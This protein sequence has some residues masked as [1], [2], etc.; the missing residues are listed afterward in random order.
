MR[1]STRL[2]KASLG[3]VD[4][5]NDEN[6]ASVANQKET[7]PRSST[8]S[9]RK[10]SRNSSLSLVVKPMVEDIE[11]K[12][13]SVEAEF[14]KKMALTMAEID[15]G[16][17][18]TSTTTK[19]ESELTP[20]RSEAGT[21]NVWN[22]V[23][24][25]ATVT[26]NRRSSV[27]KEVATPTPAPAAAGVEETKNSGSD[28]KDEEEPEVPEDADPIA[29]E[30]DNLELDEEAVIA[31]AAAEEEAAEL[32]IRNR[33]SALTDPDFD[34][35]LQEE[36]EKEE[37]YDDIDELAMGEEKEVEQEEQQQQEEVPEP[38]AVAVAPAQEE[39]EEATMPPAAP[40][41]SEEQTKPSP[42]AKSAAAE[43]QEQPQPQPK[44]SSLNLSSMMTAKI[45]KGLHGGVDLTM[46]RN[47]TTA[48]VEEKEE[49]EAATTT[50]AA[51]KPK[52]KAKI[53]KPPAAIKAPAAI[54]NNNR[55]PVVALRDRKPP[56]AA[57]AV[58]DAAA[59]NVNIKKKSVIAPRAFGTV[60]VGAK[61]T[62]V[63]SKHGSVM[64]ATTAST[65]AAMRRPFQG[66]KDVVSSSFNTSLKSNNTTDGSS[67]SSSNA[68]VSREAAR[69]AKE[70][71][72]EE[73]QI[74]VAGLKAKW[75]AEKESKL[76]KSA[77][78]R[79]ED[80]E[81]LNKLNT[82]AG[83]ARKH[84]LERKRATE[85]ARK[86][87][88]QEELAVKVED[89]L[90]VKKTVEADEKMRRRQSTALRQTIKVKADANMASI[91][92]AQEEEERG[93]LESR[94]LDAANVRAYKEQESANRRESM[95]T[96]GEVAQRQ[97]RTVELWQQE[98]RDEEKSHL[99]SRHQ[100]WED[101]QA[102]RQAEKAARRQSMAGRLD[103]WRQEKEQA[104]EQK[105]E[106]SNAS[107]EGFERKREDWKA[108][109]SF[110][111]EQK[112]QQH[113]EVASGLDKWRDER[114]M[115]AAWKAE[116]DEKANL[117]RELHNADVEDVK[118]YQ[119][120]QRDNRRKSLAF[121]LDKARSEAEYDAEQKQLQRQ[122][123]GEEARI[124]EQD[125]E[126]VKAGKEAVMASR[127]MSLEYR[128]QRA[129]Q[130]KRQ[131]QGD[132]EYQKQVDA[133]D[134]ELS[135]E[136]WRDVKRYQEKCREEQ[137]AELAA[138]LVHQKRAY[139]LDL[140]KHQ[141]SLASLHHDMETRRKD[142]KAVKAAKKEET[143]RRRKS[144]AMRLDSWRGERLKEAKAKVASLA[145]ADE[146]ARA[147]EEDREAV[148]RYKKN[149]E[150]SKLQEDFTSNFVL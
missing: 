97:K 9:S 98:Q 72:E 14:N 141:E 2:S 78:E 23:A 57:A 138:S 3:D 94:R 109:E 108:V 137:R 127:R 104:E 21:S 110:R 83:K 90:H 49:P 27:W 51:L 11:S 66:S 6:T 117:E 74:K 68:L 146:E 75:A 147:R 103:K 31:A 88:E 4:V 34:E 99:E 132:Q 18:D 140:E 63:A 126:D 16:R 56:A 60:G 134:R 54:N 52:P 19:K 139:A 46:M 142:W 92:E 93:M 135:E 100:G 128:T 81:R 43:E 1:R 124:A 7:S 118:A 148:L 40:T 89:R 77:V 15:A 133:Q 20:D 36:E 114:Q 8:A 47:I 91:K 113:Q 105:I 39:E 122:I 25:P 80:L 149:M 10:S 73:R 55:A 38:P 5:V 48:T 71:A 45:N 102:H 116:E 85:E 42:I 30:V 32:D 111:K 17:T 96:R 50:T 26:P 84:A 70:K 143:N 101:E 33:I 13:M 59:N 115:E 130:Q 41:I 121:R 125:R 22:E 86:Q 123:A 37:D 87:K 65:Q 61:K 144:I 131:E 69:A 76:N 129:I 62:T 44:R 12:L 24:T 145:Q 95:A 64:T 58:D 106:A 150:L 107:I 119:Q 53:V 67:T 82:A 136:A 28:E 29:E 120:S 35:E 112:Q 79:Q